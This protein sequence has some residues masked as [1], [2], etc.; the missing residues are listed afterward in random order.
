M[1]KK[2]MATP[3]IRMMTSESTHAKIG[4]SM[5]KRA[6]TE[7]SQG[8]NILV[9]RLRL[10]THCPRGSASLAH[11]RARIIDLALGFVQAEPAGQCVTRRSLVTRGY[12]VETA[13]SSCPGSGW[14]RT[15][16]EAPPHLPIAALQ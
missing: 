3:P 9:P 7:R 8:K 15:A 2:K 12:R 13:L 10:G 6:S 16:R 4:R 11:R 1:G 14:A 5:K